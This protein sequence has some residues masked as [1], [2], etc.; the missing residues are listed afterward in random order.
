[1]QNSVR[2]VMGCVLEKNNKQLKVCCPGNDPHVLQLH[3]LTTSIIMADS[4]TLEP[5]STCE[6]VFVDSELRHVVVHSKD[7][8]PNDY[9]LLLKQYA[10]TPGMIEDQ[11]MNSDKDLLLQG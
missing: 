5:G 6:L 8:R 9:S 7:Y 11:P 2:I 3:L 4:A 1:M 10:D